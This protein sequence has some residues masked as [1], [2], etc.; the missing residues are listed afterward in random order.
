MAL[1]TGS[2]GRL[3]ARLRRLEQHGAETEPCRVCGGESVLVLRDRSELLPFTEDG[4][5]RGCG[6]VV[7]L[8]RAIDLDLI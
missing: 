1:R 8:Y 7:K 3:S 6:A 2:S 4:H 5:C